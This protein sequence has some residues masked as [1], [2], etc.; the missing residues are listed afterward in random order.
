MTPTDEPVKSF[1]GRHAADYSK[2]HS[3][4]KGADLSAL[5]RD[6]AP[7]KDDEALDVAT[8]T[9][10]TAL[11]LSNVARRVTG[12]DVTEEMLDQAR[13]L[14]RREGASN[15]K[16][17]KG[18]AM[19][20]RYAD[21]SFDIVTTRR[22]AHHFRDVPQFLR[23]TRR[24]LRDGGRLGVVDMSPPDGAEEFVNKIERLRDSSHVEAFTPTAWK[25]MV[26]EAGFQT[27][28][29]EVLGERTLFERWLYPVGLG[30][31]EE[32][33][34]RS[35]W[36]SAPDLASGLLEADFDDGVLQS[37]TKNR[38]VLIAAKTP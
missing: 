18:D 26:T 3:H 20:M 11:A 35:A 6:L 15:L 24:V 22:A 38:L 30:G 10:F 12:I 19:K 9:G 21:G 17:E 36:E 28:S 33:A 5:I 7:K 34:I 8:G 29:V 37:F 23:E 32:A 16:F 13:D 31:P 4:A 27:T 1:F 2:S 25:A 14:A